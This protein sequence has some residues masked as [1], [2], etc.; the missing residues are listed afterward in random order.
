M[1][2]PVR[3]WPTD[4][5]GAGDRTP[6]DL[7]MGGPPVEDAHAVGQVAH[8]LCFDHDPPDVVELRRALE[9]GDEPVEALLPGR[10]AEVVEPG[11]R[12]RRLHQV[13]TLEGGRHLRPGARGPATA[14]GSARQGGGGCRASGG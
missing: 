2:V 9:V 13:V 11:G 5:D 4:D 1:V 12:G 10:L 8:Q 14:R 3:G 7:R 6:G